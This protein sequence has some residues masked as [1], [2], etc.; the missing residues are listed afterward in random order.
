MARKAL[1]KISENAFQFSSFVVRYVGMRLGQIYGDGPIL[2]N[3][4]CKMDEYYYRSIC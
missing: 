3:T 4:E 1:A 2:V